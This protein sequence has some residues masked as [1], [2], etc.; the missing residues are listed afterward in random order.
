VIALFCASAAPAAIYWGGQSPIGAANL[1]GSNPNSKYFRFHHPTG[2]VHDV[3]VSDSHLYW[4]EWFGIWRVNFEGPAT[5][6]QIVPGLNSPGGIAIDG[7]YLY[8]ANYGGNGVA[9][10][11]LDGSGR[12]DNFITGLDKPCEVAV[13]GNYVYWIGWRGIGRARLDGS[14]VEEPFIP[15][16][17]GGCGL[18][19]DAGYVYWAAAEGDIGRA[20]LDGSE[21]DP[22]FITGTGGSIGSIVVAAG[23]I[24]WTDRPNA[25]AYAS[26][27]KATL[28]L[29]PIRDWIVPPLFSIG[30]VAVDARPSP[31]PLPLPSRPIYFGKARHDNRT[32]TAVIDVSVPERGDLTVLAPKLGW[33]VLKGPA[34][35]PWHG[36]SFRWR[37]KVWP[38]TSTKGKK[39]RTQLRNK[40]RAKVALR[41]SYA[42]EGQLPLTAMKRLT[43]RKK[44]QL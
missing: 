6:V 20:R 19:V 33:K 4:G 31:P 12:N 44:K 34:P 15:T 14:E 11:A 29:A 8:W 23:Q 36:G 2:P 17:P 43:L 37:L 21:A 28:G 10:A 3:A 40:G 25:M 27:D 41:L 24:Y 38:G 22:R 39:I 9:R 7:S 42:E 18:A 5:P 13:D 35:P 26:I 30:G 16:A 32:G 1:D